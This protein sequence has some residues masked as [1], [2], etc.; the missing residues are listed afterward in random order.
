[1]FKDNAFFLHGVAAL[2]AFLK[3]VPCIWIVQSG[4]A[5]YQASQSDQAL[6]NVVKPLI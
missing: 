1:M 3:V 5:F 6:R 4:R 2:D